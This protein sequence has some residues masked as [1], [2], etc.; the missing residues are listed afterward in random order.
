[1]SSDQETPLLR[2]P[3][4]F[5]GSHDPLARAI[6]GRNLREM[7]RLLKKGAPVNYVVEYTSAS[8]LLLALGEYPINIKMMELLLDHGASIDQG[9]E[10]HGTTPLMAVCSYKKLEVSQLLLQRGASVARPRGSR[11]G[12]GRRDA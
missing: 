9:D 12:S 11:R 8:P 10:I 5:M 4:Q 1:M 6:I 7:S 3:P 2:H